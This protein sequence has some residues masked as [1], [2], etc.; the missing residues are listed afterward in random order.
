MRSTWLTTP[1]SAADA[2]TPRASPG[3]W[4][5]LWRAASTT[6]SHPA[7]RG[8]VRSPAAPP[9]WPRPTEQLAQTVL[10]G[11]P[12]RGGAVRGTGLGEDP[13]DVALDGVCAQKKIGRDVGVRLAPGDQ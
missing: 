7:S 5:S 13:V 9:G 10:V 12:D 11:V 8:T 2:T 1:W 6:W 4:G 3:W